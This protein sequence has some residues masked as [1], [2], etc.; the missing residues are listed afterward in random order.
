MAGMD[1]ILEQLLSRN[2]QLQECASQIVAAGELLISSFASGG[3]LL[4]CGNGGSAADA[5]HIVG[6]LMKGFQK[7]RP[8]S[9]AEREN[10][11]RLYPG[12]KLGERLQGA[13]PAI[14]LSAHT[15]FGTACVNDNGA[16]MV[17]AQQVWGYGKPGDVLLAL[18]TSGNSENVIQAVKTAHA[19][20]IKSIAI[21]GG[22]GGELGKQCSVFV[23]LP[24]SET[25]LVQELTLPIY[26]AL[27]RMAEGYFWKV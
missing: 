9:K 4:V 7:K 23:M 15:A 24:E 22:T 21:C 6:E 26:H 2:P 17:F 13:L 27:C 11:E 5:E 12:E 10:L 18:S 16:D 3:K 1:L 20:G 8:L 14:A 19:A 25:Y